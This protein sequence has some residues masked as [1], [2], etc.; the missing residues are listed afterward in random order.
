M[1]KTFTTVVLAFE[2]GSQEVLTFP[3]VLTWNQQQHCFVGL[4]RL[5]DDSPPLGAIVITRRNIAQFAA[6]EVV[7][8]AMQGRSTPVAVDIVAALRAKEE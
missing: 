6:H 3:Y 4:M 1:A 8:M 2:D 5:R 7:V